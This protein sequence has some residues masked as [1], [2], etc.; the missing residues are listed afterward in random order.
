MP[1]FQFI[2]RPHPMIDNA[3]QRLYRLESGTV[4]SA[5]RANDSERW[6]AAVLDEAG[7][8][9]TRTIF[10]KADKLEQDVLLRLPEAEL[11]TMLDEIQSWEDKHR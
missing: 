11:L 1:K 9:L 4:L 3:T 6:E 10:P 5:F 2:E 8:W 7:E